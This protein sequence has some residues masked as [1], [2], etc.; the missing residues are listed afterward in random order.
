MSR[1]IIVDQ[2]LK[3]LGGHH[4]DY[5]LQV[6]Q[7][8]SRQGVEVIVVA[9]QQ[10]SNHASLQHYARIIPHFRRTTYSRYSLLAGLRAMH[11]RPSL[12]GAPPNLRKVIPERD[13]DSWGLPAIDQERIPSNAPRSSQQTTLAKLWQALTNRGG[14]WW[15]S[16]QTLATRMQDVNGRNRVVQS[17]ASDCV[18]V[19][20]GL[21]LMPSDHVF[22]ATIN[23]LELA[24]L[25]VYWMGAPESYLPHWH[26]Q[27]HF[28][29]FEGRVPE[30]RRQYRVLDPLRCLFE[31]IDNAV[32][33]HQLHYYATTAAI[34]DQ[35]QRLANR[36][37][38]ELA[39]PISESFRSAK[40][41]PPKVVAIAANDQADFARSTD[42]AARMIGRLDPSESRSIQVA[43]ELPAAASES[44]ASSNFPKVPLWNPNASGIPIVVAGGI[45]SEKGQKGLPEIW[46]ELKRQVLDAGLGFIV[47]QRQEKRQW[48]RQRFS[49][50]NSPGQEST[51]ASVQY[52]PHPLST[53]Q[54]Q[55]LIRQAGIGLLTYDPRSYANRRAGIFGEY[56]ASGVPTLVPAGTWMADQLAPYQ[57]AYQQQVLKQNPSLACWSHLDFDWTPWNVPTASG[58]VT[59]DGGEVPAYAWSPVIPGADSATNDRLLSLRLHWVWPREAGTFCRIEILFYDQHRQVIT[60]DSATIGQLGQNTAQ[61][62]LFRIPTE[63]VHF[64]LGLK[65]AFYDRNATIQ[66]LLVDVVSSDH[67]LPLGAVG[68]TYDSLSQIPARLSELC[69]HHSHYKTT[70]QRVAD[71]WFKQHDPG[72]TVMQLMNVESKA[73]RQR[74]G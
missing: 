70:C 57:V 74:A 7:A 52:L 38:T 62:A 25:L 73:Q 49:L 12:V 55:E 61:S 56:L 48:Y 11:R 71:A 3:G 51:D 21:V 5:V 53:P 59:F 16:F 22:F 67:P 58:S 63:A 39:Y 69:T 27:F 32:P 24:G 47:C 23:D 6:S 68:L 2:S 50:P 20:P 10:F 72:A 1:L 43:I 17:F 31:D 40:A 45:R 41:M 34:A 64:R 4:F 65:N 54:Y 19:F 13:H 42:A 66:R 18:R 28:D 44:D 36:P 30:Y 15:R 9:H 35:Y 37:I 60:A 29:A 8:A 33:T 26:L 14:R 46:A